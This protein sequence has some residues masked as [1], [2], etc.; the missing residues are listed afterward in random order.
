MDGESA[1]LVET[2]SV[3]ELEAVKV[4]ANRFD[5]GTGDPSDWPTMLT[6]DEFTLNSYES[7]P[8]SR[9]PLPGEKDVP[10]TVDVFNIPEGLEKPG[11]MSIFKK[12]KIEP[13]DIKCIPSAD[14]TGI[15][16]AFVEVSNLK[17]ALK[18]LE[19]LDKKPPLNLKVSLAQP[20]DAYVKKQEIIQQKNIKMA[21]R[22]FLGPD[23]DAPQSQN[24]ED[25]AQQAPIEN[26]MSQEPQTNGDSSQTASTRKPKPK[27]IG[28]RKIIERIRATSNELNAVDD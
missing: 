2:L 22:I 28:L 7:G 5:D 13:L 3:G 12:H 23:A 26:L 17:S 8:G 15:M 14:G 1:G 4:G 24:V 11:I 20:K 6:I 21:R 19:M 27:P 16:R 25:P 10:I 9:L 18:A